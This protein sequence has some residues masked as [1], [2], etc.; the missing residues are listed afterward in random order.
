MK[1]RLL[2]LRFSYF[3]VFTGNITNTVFYVNSPSL[4]IK[5][6]HIVSRGSN[7]FFFVFSFLLEIRQVATRDRPSP[8]RFPKRPPSPSPPGPASSRPRRRAF[9]PAYVVQRPQER[10]SGV[11]GH[12]Q[13]L[14]VTVHVVDERPQPRLG[15]QRAGHER[16]VLE[17]SGQAL[18][19]VLH[20]R[21]P[22]VQFSADDHLRGFLFFEIP[23]TA[24][25]R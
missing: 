9:R 11:D 23:N 18:Y 15:V 21:V 8:L 4:G 20:V 6:R 10:L 3:T 16:R 13:L 25:T 5:Y 7:G 12:V 17:S 22:I 14:L 19:F 1:T 2:I 24:K